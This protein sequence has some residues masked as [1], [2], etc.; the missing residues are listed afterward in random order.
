M[1]GA[2]TVGAA[3]RE[4][5]RQILLVLPE[6]VD[7]DMTRP[8]DHRPARRPGADPEG[9]QWGGSAETEVREVAVKPTGPV[10]PRAV[11]TATPAA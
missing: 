10:S 7:A 5:G 9:E 2:E 6:Y 4:G 8:G 11:T 1:G 3:A